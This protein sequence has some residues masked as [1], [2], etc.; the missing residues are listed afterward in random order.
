MAIPEAA[1]DHYRTMLGLQTLTVKAGQVAWSRVESANVAASWIPALASL[2]PVV[3]KAQRRAAFEGATYS[4]MTL[5]QQSDYT[6]PDAFVDVDAFAGYASDGRALGSLLAQP[7]LG[8]QA[9]L[10][11]GMPRD[12][13]LQSGLDAL[14]RMLST[15]VADAGRQAGGIDVASRAAVGYIRMVRP[16]A[17]PRCSIQAGKWFRWN[18]GFLRHPRCSC[19]HVANRAG[20]TQG[21]LDEGLVKD[22]YEAFKSLPAAEQDRIY[23]AANARAIRDGADISQVANSRRGM[24][25]TGVFTSEGTTSAGNAAKGLKPRQRRMTP[26]GIYRQGELNGKDRQWTLDRLEE[27]GYILPGGQNPTGSL[28]G[29]REGF[30]QLGGGGKRAAAS[31]AIEDARRTGVR[32]PNSRYTMTAAERRVQDAKNKYET[33]LSGRSPYRSNPAFTN[34]PDP[35]GSLLYV[36]S[37]RASNSHF[38]PVTQE[39]L[40]QAERSYRLWLASR[41]QVFTE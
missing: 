40:A 32:D 28:W 5:A 22:P 9:L 35:S 8:V 41:G 29:Q 38:V 18:A 10:D 3:E 26:E 21:A 27:H 34:K 23:G 2:V 31:E 24:T 25:K 36:G 7:A 4:A 1:Q 12:L 14:G 20:S 37:G 30:G 15:Q 19:V 33:A 13:A 39:E 6:A 11:G 16:G 17:C